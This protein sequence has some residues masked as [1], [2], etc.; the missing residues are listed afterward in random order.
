MIYGYIR[1]SSASQVNNSSLQHQKDCLIKNGAKIIITEVGSASKIGS[2]TKLLDLIESL[3][4]NDTLMVL[5]F[6][7]FCRTTLEGLTLIN[8][9]QEK[10]AIFN[11]LDFRP[12]G[13]L[14]SDQFT[15]ALF[16]TLA[17]FETMRR[18][19]RQLVGIAKAKKISGKYKGRKPKIDSKG[20]EK[21]AYYLK[22]EMTI[23]EIAKLMGVAKSTLYRHIKITRNVDIIKTKET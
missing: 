17:E 11:S 15:T 20:R 10:K 23:T 6:D 8:K 22:K 4:P 2:R 21:I 13:D 12:T 1:V 18:R 3:Q 5:K 7:R 9:I 19:Q 16:S 14:A